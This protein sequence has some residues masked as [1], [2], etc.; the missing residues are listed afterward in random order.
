MYETD[1]IDFQWQLIEAIVPDTRRRK[2]LIRLIFNVLIY[3][4]KI[5]CQWRVGQKRIFGVTAITCRVNV[6]AAGT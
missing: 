6:T 4:I 3:L 2:H 1:L 5:D